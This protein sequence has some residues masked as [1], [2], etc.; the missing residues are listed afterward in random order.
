MSTKGNR[1]IDMLITYRV[2]K[3]LTTPFEKQDAFKFGIIDKDGKVLR[4][5]KDVSKSDEKKTYTWLHR[6][7]FN[8]KRLLGKA[9]LGGRLGS[10]GVALALLLKEENYINRQPKKIRKL[11]EPSIGD[12]KKYDKVFESAVIKYCVHIGVW[13]TIL[14]EDVN[15]SPTMTGLLQEK[16]EKNPDLEL[17]A[18]YFGCDIFENEDKST[19]TSSRSNN[20]MASFM[21]RGET[22]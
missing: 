3:I 1:T 6:F 8:V 11:M 15:L 2:L 16:F 5:Y 12:Y 17:T 18:N 19:V 14:K 21:I 22:V 9:G 10:L 7:V 20:A 13:D 4:R